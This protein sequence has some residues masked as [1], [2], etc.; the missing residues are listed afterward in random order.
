MAHANNRSKYW[1]GMD[2]VRALTLMA[3]RNSLET[4]YQDGSIHCNRARAIRSAKHD[5]AR[6]PRNTWA[7]K[8][9]YHWDR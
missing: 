6:K 7:S 9:I 5:A 1:F 2:N 4:Y 3:T 8:R